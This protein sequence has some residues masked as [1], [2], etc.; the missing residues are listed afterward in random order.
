MPV[1]PENDK[2]P[3]SL[4]LAKDE[5]LIN[6]RGT[7]FI[8][9]GSSDFILITGVS[10]LHGRPLRGRIQNDLRGKFSQ[11][12]GI[13]SLHTNIRLFLLVPSARFTICHL[14]YHGAAG[15]AKSR[16]QIFSGSAGSTI[17]V[18]PVGQRPVDE[19]T[20]RMFAKVSYRSGPPRFP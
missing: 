7:T 17:Y 12:S 13:Y 6:F 14:G 3:P 9:E 16:R 15:F 2:K 5:S 11:P 18:Y 8:D 19:N 1:T 10:V 20:A 4:D